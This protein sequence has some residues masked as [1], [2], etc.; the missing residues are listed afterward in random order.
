MRAFIENPLVKGAARRQL[1]VDSLMYYAGYSAMPDIV[2]N[3]TSN[4][5]PR[6]SY[7][8]CVGWCHPNFF[9]MANIASHRDATMH[10]V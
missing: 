5:I 6:D 2:N 1:G 7:D 9:R 8:G 3:L 4:V 10:I